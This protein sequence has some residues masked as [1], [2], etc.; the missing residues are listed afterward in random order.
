MA[1]PT[2]SSI[3][4]EIYKNSLV[5][6]AGSTGLKFFFVFV[7]FPSGSESSVTLVRFS[8]VRPKMTR[9]MRT[10][11]EILTPHAQHYD[12]FLQNF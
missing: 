11:I 7:L 9:K 1:L 10:T 2:T 12:Y 4:N 3:N 6:P 5:V 8:K